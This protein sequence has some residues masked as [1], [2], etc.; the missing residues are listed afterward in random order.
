M[1]SRLTASLIAL[2]TLTATAGDNIQ[3]YFSPKGGCTEAVVQAL[4]T[5]QSEVLV[6]AYSFTSAPIAGALRD[7]YRRGVKVSVVLDKS[8]Q[9]DRY[10]SATFLS[11]SG[12]RTL[13]DA[14]HA[15]AHSKY[16]VID[17]TTV[18]TGSFNFTKAAEEANA[19]NMLVIRESDLAGKYAANWTEHAGHSKIYRLKK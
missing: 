7:A 1:L 13:I 17:R 12:I 11:N 6:A 16:M 19:E 10:T 2:A 14:K 3:V 9:T 15:I 8:N 4:K 5:A 18:I